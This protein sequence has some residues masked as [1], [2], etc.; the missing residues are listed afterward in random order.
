M[1][2]AR[3]VQACKLTV[4]LL[5]GGIISTRRSYFGAEVAKA[6]RAAVY[7]DAG[8]ILVAL[9]IDA[10]VAISGPA[11]VAGVLHRRAEAKIGSS[12]IECVAAP[13]INALALMGK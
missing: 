9:L 5:S 1:I 11:A 7:S 12:V 8:T 13:V 10:L 6:N 2:G 4:M 3:K